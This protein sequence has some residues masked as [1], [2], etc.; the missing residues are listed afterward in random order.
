[1]GKITPAK[2]PPGTYRDEPDRNDAASTSSAVLLGEIDYSDDADFPPDA[3]LP[4]YEDAA[5]T[6]SATS[7][8]PVVDDD[9]E[10]A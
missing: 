5:S 9:G 7:A 6:S 10:Q 1:M 8:R 3:D 4:S 2:P